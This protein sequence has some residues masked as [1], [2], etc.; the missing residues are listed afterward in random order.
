MSAVRA[1]LRLLSQTAFFTYGIFFGGSFLFPGKP[2]HYEYYYWAVLPFAA[3]LAP[4]ALKLLRISPLFWLVIAYTLYMLMASAWSQ[5]FLMDDFLFHCRRILYVLAFILVTVVLLYEYPRQFEWLLKITCAIAALTAVAAI[6]LWYP[7]HAF[8]ESR[9]QGIG[10][11]TAPH[12]S[13]A[14]FGFFGV[15]ALAYADRERAIALRIGFGLSAALIFAFVIATQSR[16]G[17]LAF[18][19]AGLTLTLPQHPKKVLALML[20]FAAFAAVIWIFLPVLADGLARG[21]PYRPAIWSSAFSHA[22]EAP[23]FGHGSLSATLVML[24]PNTFVHAHSPFLGSFRDG[25]I[26]GLALLVA[27][28]GYAC[29]A[30]LRY[31][32]SQHDTKY[33]SLWI[34]MMICITP[35]MDRLFVRPNELWMYFWLP[36]VFLIWQEILEPRDRTSAA[37][38]ETSQGGLENALS[39]QE[40]SCS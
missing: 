9:L 13:A 35:N 36:L 6:V 2:E 26:I 1:P 37:V 32:R 20:V 15:L 24:P 39:A 27:L 8:P 38:S 7:E 11:F 23:I 33:L 34:Y 30:A 19:L 5:P 4:T 18:V 21:L 22:M 28:L 10:K 16:T 12:G 40:R 31:S 14:A 3:I 25:G 17:V 29:V